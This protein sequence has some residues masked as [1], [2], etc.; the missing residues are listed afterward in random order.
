MPS[1]PFS[2]T[3][4]GGATFRPLEHWHY[5]RV[6][7]GGVVQL[8]HRATAVAMVCTFYTGSEGLL[9]R[10]PVPAGG[11]AGVTPSAFD[12]APITDEVAA[13]DKLD[14]QYENTSGAPI[15]VDGVVVYQW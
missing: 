10:S 8:I 5:E 6:P 13:S 4:A 2:E 12:V 9:Q 15:T 11:T 3:V 1:F 7:V 14:L